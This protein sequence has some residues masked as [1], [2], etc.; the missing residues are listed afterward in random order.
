MTAP[1]NGRLPCTVPAP[2]PS[3]KVRRAIARERFDVL[4]LHEPM[5]PAIC[6]ATLALARVP[7]VA[8]F[9][10]NGDLGW[11]KIG[12]PIWGFLIDRLDQR[13]AVSPHA[14]ATAE[15]WLPGEYHVVPNGVLIPALADAGGREQR[16]LFAGRQEP[17]KG[18]PVL[19]RA[20]PEI[21]RRRGARL[22]IAG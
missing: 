17:R 3:G 4:R 5:T 13:I 12:M 22:R 16:V 6:I 14:Q 20:W 10:A 9:H 7:M 15:R 11:M 1:A 18:L 8:T 2:Q 21:R 19:L